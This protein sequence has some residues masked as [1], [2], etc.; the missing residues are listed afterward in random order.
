MDLNNLGEKIIL[1]LLLELQ[2]TPKPGCVDKEYE[3]EDTTFMDFIYSSMAVGRGF[4]E[5]KTQKIG[6]IIYKTTKEMIKSHSGVNTHFGA[7]LLHAPLFK[8]ANELEKP[9]LDDLLTK[10]KGILEYSD[11]EDSINFFNAIN[12]VEIGGL[13]KRNELDAGSTEAISE[14]SER[15]ISF[16]ELMNI[17]KERD[18]IAKELID[19]YQRTKKG[20]EFLKKRELNNK[21]LV[22]TFIFHLQ[23][24]DT[25]VSKAFSPST[26]E[27][28]S[29]E[30]KDIVKNDFPIKKINRLNR[31]LNKDSISP[32]TT[33]DILSST[34]L[35][36]LIRSNN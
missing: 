11:V 10:A 3:H 12:L 35:L 13:G 28:I 36:K 18:D 22:D 2:T 31:K 19:G 9:S 8:A 23:E 20:Y 14:I 15:N 1:S 6:E 16:F 25:H 26:A 21:N 27:E 32:G 5:N 33:A 17:S 4:R 29:K 34:I 7:I 24:P 30:A